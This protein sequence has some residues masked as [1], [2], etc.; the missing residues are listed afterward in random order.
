METDDGQKSQQQ[1]HKC[2]ARSLR[3][4][5]ITATVVIGNIIHEVIVLEIKVRY[6]IQKVGGKRVSLF[7]GLDWT[8]V[9]WTGVTEPTTA[10]LRN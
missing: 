10:S 3:L 8:G 4:A 2:R 1:T 5:P 9:D 7:A 6:T